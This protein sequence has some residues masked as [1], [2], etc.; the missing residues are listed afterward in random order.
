MS[1]VHTES[2]RSITRKPAARPSRW[3]VGA[4]LLAAAG[5]PLATL[6]SSQVVATP[7]AAPLATLWIAAIVA[8]VPSR[9][10]PRLPPLALAACGALLAAGSIAEL[11]ILQHAAAIVCLVSVCRLPAAMLLFLGSLVWLPATAAVF[12]A[13]ASGLRV[14]A[15]ACCVAAVAVRHQRVALR[16]RPAWKPL[17]I[18]VVVVGGV[19]TASAFWL[20]TPQSTSHLQNLP[21]QG[22]LYTSAPLPLSSGESHHLRSVDV[23]KRRYR[24]P[25]ATFDLLA[26]DGSANRHAVHDPTFCHRGDGWEIVSRQSLPLPRGEALWVRYRR[27]D[28]STQCVYWFTNAAT[29][30]PNTWWFWAAASWRR[31]TAGRSGCEPVLVVLQ[32]AADVAP[33]WTLVFRECPALAAY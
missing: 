5:V 16:D 3:L 6:A 29:Q 25:S 18:G 13:W 1:H 9:R 22:L 26:I 24:V 21:Q 33:D 20:G 23:V 8:S 28:E 19:L 27:G 2:P 7:L 31:L 14:F 4:V 10:C 32:P 12:G 17:A 15:A 30:T 11:R